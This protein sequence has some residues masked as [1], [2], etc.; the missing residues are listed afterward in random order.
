MTFAEFV[1][2]L[3]EAQHLGAS[4]RYYGGDQRRVKDAEGKEGWR[5]ADR[6]LAAPKPEPSKP[7]RRARV[8]SREDILSDRPGPLYS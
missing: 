7:R 8:W 6:F 3:P 5:A 4:S 1:D 2:T